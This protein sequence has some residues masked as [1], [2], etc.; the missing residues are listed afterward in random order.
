MMGWIRPRAARRTLG[1]IAVSVGLSVITLGAIGATP[2]FAGLSVG[3]VSVALSSNA[4]GATGVQYTVGFVPATGLIDYYGTVNL[5]APAGTMINPT[6]GYFGLQDNTNGSTCQLNPVAG[7]S[8]GATFTGTVWGCSNIAGGDQLVI[9]V[10]DTTNPSSPSSG[11][12]IAVSTSSDTS[13]ANSPAYS[14]VAPSPATITFLGIP[15]DKGAVGAAY[16]IGFNLSATGGLETNYSS[17]TVTAGAGTNFV[18]TFYGDYQLTDTTVGATCYLSPVTVTNSGATVSGPLY[19]CPATFA[20][21]DHMV[22]TL[23]DVSNPKPAT[24]PASEQLSL[25]TTS[26]TT[27]ATASYS[28]V[29]TTSVT[30]TSVSLSSSAP[31]ATSTYTLGWVTSAS[32][33]LGSTNQNDYSTLTLTGP[34]GTVFSSNYPDYNL[35][36][37]TQNQSCQLNPVNSSGATLTANLSYCSPIN[38]G[39][40]VVLTAN[41]T[42]NPTTTSTTDKI[43]ISTSS[44]LKAA[45]SPTYS[46]AT[47]G[48]TSI[49]LSTSAKSAP[50]T[51]TVG[52]LANATITGGTGTVA[53][54]APTGTQWPSSASNYTVNDV[55]QN[56]QCSPQGAAISGTK[57]TLTISTCFNINSGDQVVITVTDVVNPATIAT[58]DSISIKESGTSTTL[59]TPQYPITAPKA[60]VSPTVGLTSTAAMA[61]G[62]TYN[63]QF[64]ASSSG[65][66]AGFYSTITLQA[67]TG[68]VFSGNAGDYN[69]LDLTTGNSCSIYAVALSNSS[70]T[71]TITD[72]CGIAGGDLITL[73]VGNVSNPGTTSTGDALVVSTSSDSVTA[74]TA[75]TYSIVPSSS[76]TGVS[77]TP[78]TTAAGASGVTYTVTFHP[79]S[80][81]ADFYGTITVNAPA[82]TVLSS[83]SGDFTLRDATLNTSCG[84]NYENLANSG[85]TATVTIW[86]CGN[87]N[88]GDQVV[89]TAGN[90]TNPPAPATGLL[91]SVA[92]SSDPTPAN[93]GPY[94][95]TAPQS[96]QSTSIGL[97]SAAPGATAVTY[98]V[99]F[100]TSSTGALATYNQQLTLSAPAGTVFSP[101]NGDYTLTDLNN[102]S[103]CS[104]NNV[105]TSNGGATVSGL[106][107]G[108]TVNAGDQLSLAANNT[109]NPL[110]ASTADVIAISTSADSV[111]AAT[112][113]YSIGGS[114]TT[115]V[116]T[117]TSTVWGKTVTYQATVSGRG[118]TPTGTV[119]V[120][121]GAT[122]LCTVTLANGAGSC[123]SR[124][125]PVGTQTISAT[126]SGDGNFNPSTGSTSLVVAQAATS[127]AATATPA[128]PP[129]VYGQQ[130]TYGATVT[131]ATSGSTG[132]PTGSVTFSVGSTVLC[133]ATLS[134]GAGSCTGNQASAGSDSVTASYGGDSGFAAAGGGT[135]LSVA[136]ASTSVSAGATPSS[137]LIGQSV[138][139]SA[140][141][142]DTT[143]G[144]SGVPTGTVTFNVGATVLCTATLAAGSGS[145]TA[146]NAPA[147]SDTV[148]AAYHGDPNFAASTGS[149]SVSVNLL[150]SSTALVV[151]PSANPSV[152]GQSVTY[153]V[154]VTDG[155]AGTTGTPT[156][157]VTIAAGTKVLC[158]KP[159]S[160]GAASCSSVNAPAGSDAII[161]T[162]LGDAKFA[163]STTSQSL[164]VAAATTTTTAT[165]T[166]ATSPD[167]YGQNVTYSSTV[168]NTSSGSTLTPNGSVTFTVGTAKMCT[169]TLNSSGQGSCTSNKAAVGSGTVT[170]SYA[171]NTSF[172]AST[173]TTALT[174]SQD[175]TATGVTT[176][177]TSATSGQSVSY[178][179]TVTNTT[180][181]STAAPT[182]SVT[183][184]SGTVTLCTATVQANG[185]AT[186]SSTKAPKGTDT[187]TATYKGSTNF[188]PSSGTTQLTVS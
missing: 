120:A 126:Y 41:N 27:P 151:T 169:A 91:A 141:V 116:T 30:P 78:S 48:S 128:T 35:R 73:S 94:A 149:T 178:Q 75:P 164:T 89:L 10:T 187:I 172:G 138:T 46:I 165:A 79:A 84:V 82:G 136:Q 142:A 71:A 95:S 130:V 109:A 59:T 161:A 26:D 101:N 17:I 160:A 186:C 179:A 32:G 127:V 93:S 40:Q 24:V 108:C 83:N 49:A 8:P 25:T 18:S 107:W 175:S 11:D 29:A 61:T 153:Q 162:Y 106:V 137:S 98:T 183:F 144:S 97:S 131:D 21:G 52:F 50:G 99:G 88:A 34:A 2:A 58:T 9:T 133:T 16:S 57:T 154:S 19:G 65:G 103:S 117:V 163:T 122:P 44:D 114:T 6:Y 155:S 185:T 3:S 152:Y 68:T 85:A 66:L 135:T 36:D 12:Q 113:A 104:L 64:T 132:T 4:A 54:T 14:I 125:A 15:N 43:S 37:V 147:G 45:S 121:A 31:G 181:G 63:V 148:T 1:A 168:T 42:T 177:P 33:Q 96:V 180:S 90:T 184:T 76:V 81:L 5:T 86:G 80:G 39:D 156:G 20:S 70:A 105:A 87:I 118:G 123:S 145:C 111:V 188:L 157:S 170:A 72:Y 176:N 182:G 22:L 171:G 55:T 60:V 143:S 69:I 110:T 150:A 167:A 51:Y 124:L 102:G 77:V 62:V 7:Q 159:L 38:A 166:P 119:A 92:T 112:P 23:N 67:P 13:P 56:T 47:P 146:T 115:R 134:S 158:T 174:V 129:D 100:T 74:Q 53:L 139:Y 173:G 28:I 140:T